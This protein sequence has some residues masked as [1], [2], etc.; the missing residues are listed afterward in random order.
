M[1]E[2]K[3]KKFERQVRSSLNEMVSELKKLNAMREM[4]DLR[5]SS[6]TVPGAYKIAVNLSM[7]KF[8]FFNT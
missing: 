8:D 7:D 4:I 6:R 5:L 2:T 3:R 1:K